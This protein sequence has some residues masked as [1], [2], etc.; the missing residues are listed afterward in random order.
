MEYRACLRCGSLD[1]AMPGAG[2]GVTFEGGQLLVSACRACGMT[3]PPVVFG[4]RAAWELFRAERAV[5]YTAEPTPPGDF[6]V[7]PPPEMPTGP[8]LRGAAM[9]GVAAIVGMLFVVGAAAAVVT[10]AQ[11]GGQAW[12][13]LLPGALVSLLLGL[14]ILA[15]AGRRG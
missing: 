10:A 1:L 12:G 11:T 9:R 5:L 14:P 2:D 7:R 3:G 13:V 6:A 4:D 8:G 15:M